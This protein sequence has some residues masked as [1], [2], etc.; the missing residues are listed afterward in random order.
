MHSRQTISDVKM[1]EYL[2]IV[3]NVWNVEQTGI[4]WRSN[5]M[6]IGWRVTVMIGSETKPS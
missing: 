3:R 1:H 6:L 4:P 5:E 2:K